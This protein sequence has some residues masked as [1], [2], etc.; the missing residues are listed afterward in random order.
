MGRARADDI[1]AAAAF[2]SGD[3][4]RDI[5][6]AFGTIHKELKPWHDTMSRENYPVLRCFGA[7]LN[8]SKQVFELRS[9]FE[10]M[11]PLS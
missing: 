11:P 10:N 5:L 8:R 2:G 1:Q 9:H 3:L 6:A 7:D 4:I